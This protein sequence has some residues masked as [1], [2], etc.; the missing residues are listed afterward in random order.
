[1]DL[2]GIEP[3]TAHMQFLKLFEGG[4]KVLSENYTTKPQARIQAAA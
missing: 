4:R 2:Q 3:W 1:M